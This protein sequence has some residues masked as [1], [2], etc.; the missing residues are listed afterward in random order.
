MEF[1]TLNYV[2]RFNNCRIHES[3]DY[4]PPVEFEAHYYAQSES[5]DL[6]VLKTI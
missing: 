1:V 6:A 2:D 5:E 4:V 3:L